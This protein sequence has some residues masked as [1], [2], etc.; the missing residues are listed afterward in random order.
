[1]AAGADVGQINP[2]NPSNA[3]RTALTQ[4]ACWSFR[5]PEMM[6]QY[7]W[8]VLGLLSNARAGG[9]AV[10]KIQKTDGRIQTSYDRSYGA[11]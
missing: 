3:G 10:I 4:H 6:G 5:E 9:V 8:T 11:S 7:V 1:V 2:G